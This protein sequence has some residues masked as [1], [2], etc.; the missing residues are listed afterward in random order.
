MLHLKYSAAHIISAAKGVA[1]GGGCEI[2]L[3]SSHIVANADLNSG[4]VE[5]GVSLVPGW[6]GITEMFVRS[7]GDK[8]KLIRNIRNI[9]EQN[10]SSSADY[11]K[12]DYS[13]ENISI[14]M[15][16]HYILEEALALKLPKKIVP[17][18]HK[19]TLP[20]IDLAKE[21]DT[22]KYDDLQNKVLTKFQNI[23]DKHNET[24]EEELMEYEREI[25]L[26][27]AKDSKTI[28]KLKVII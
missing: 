11:F 15:N 27:L 25:F 26:E 3:H 23:I 21:I 7:K 8:A 20:K 4:L 6:G 1:L 5:F 18:P 28:E 2:L 16:K 10:K 19:L 9:L 14:N 12:A 22:S 17:A 13:V 24:N